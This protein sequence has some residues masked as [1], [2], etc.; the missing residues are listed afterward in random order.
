MFLDLPE[1]RKTEQFLENIGTLCNRIGRLNNFLDIACLNV[2]DYYDSVRQGV[3][4]LKQ[5]E[6]QKSKGID[7]V[8]EQEMIRWETESTRFLKRV[9]QGDKSAIKLGRLLFV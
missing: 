7:H 2:E 4:L 5:I 3:T 6:G 8:L 1:G 9:N